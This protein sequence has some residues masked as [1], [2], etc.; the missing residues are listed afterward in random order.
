V[1]LHKQMQ[2]SEFIDNK[3]SR[4]RNGY[5]PPVFANRMMLPFADSHLK[6][7]GKTW[8]GK[9]ERRRVGGLEWAPLQLMMI[10]KR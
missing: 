3:S 8:P 2:D 9:P 7:G 6:P 5:I 1:Q 10:M 4:D